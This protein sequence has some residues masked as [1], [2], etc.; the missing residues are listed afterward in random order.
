[1]GAADRGH[2]PG[3]A[4]AVAVEHRQGPEVDR[5]RRQR[6]HHDVADRFEEG[7]PVMVDDALRVTGGPRGVVER[8]RRALIGRRRPREVVG[9]RGQERFV[10][11]LAEPVAWALVERVVD[12]DDQRLSAKLLEGGSDRGGELPVGQ[13]DLGFTVLEDVGDRAR[14]EPRVDRVEHGPDHGDAE[15]RVERRRHIRQDGRHGIARADAAAGECRGQAP[16]PQVEVAIHDAP[17]AVDHRHAL[18]IDRRGAREK[19]ERAQRREVGGGA[20]ETPLEHIAFRI[21]HAESPPPG[22]DLIAAIGA[23]QAARGGSE[24]EDFGAPMAQSRQARADAVLMLEV[25]V[26]DDDPLRLGRAGQHG[27]PRVDDHRVAVA[28]ETGRV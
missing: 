28:R 4:P 3:V 15:V 12:L 17:I 21:R 13:Q 7:P 2:R 8:D 11:D 22:P 1:M 14:V 6:P 9:A 27:A 20:P 26:G 19:P 18:R 25:D 5:A 16:S 10:L 23:E 24:P